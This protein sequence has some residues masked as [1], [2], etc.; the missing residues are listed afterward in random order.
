MMNTRLFF[1]YFSYSQEMQARQEKKL[2][3]KT[4]PCLI[5]FKSLRSHNLLRDMGS[6]PHAAI[7]VC[8]TLPWLSQGEQAPPRLL[9]LPAGC[10]LH[11]QSGGVIM[12]QQALWA[13][14]GTEHPLCCMTVTEEQTCSCS[15]PVL[16]GTGT[17]TL[18]TFQATQMLGTPFVLVLGLGPWLLAPGS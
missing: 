12:P 10:L 17:N 8:A 1:F 9:G 7:P 2:S 15:P 14:V 5:I 6:G 3:L 18:V 4:S 11:E 13:S 16:P